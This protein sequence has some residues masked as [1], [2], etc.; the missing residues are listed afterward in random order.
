VKKMTGA[1]FVPENLEVGAAIG[2]GEGYEVNW[3]MLVEECQRFFSA[4]TG[5]SS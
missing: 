4:I 1:V 3:A 5:K 2:L